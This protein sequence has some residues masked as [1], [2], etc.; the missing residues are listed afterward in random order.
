MKQHDFLANVEWVLLER[1]ALPAPFVP[2]S[3]LVY[4][5]DVVPALSVDNTTRPLV[6]VLQD[7]F[8]DWDYVA[9]DA[10]YSAELCQ[11]VQ[12]SGASAVLAAQPVQPP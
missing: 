3:S 4:A 7:P 12:K 2:D 1:M 5:Q 10:H 9:S 11:F 8:S 6:P